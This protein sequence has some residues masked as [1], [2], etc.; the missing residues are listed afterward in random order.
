MIHATPLPAAERMNSGQ[1]FISA[2]RSSSFMDSVLF[3]TAERGAYS[4]LAIRR[5]CNVAGS[6]SSE[7]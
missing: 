5:A 3:L 4:W 7:K 2:S 1:R 6:V